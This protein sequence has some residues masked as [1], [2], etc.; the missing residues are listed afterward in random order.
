MVNN[1]FLSTRLLFY[2]QFWTTWTTWTG[3]KSIKKK[4]YIKI[5]ESKHNL[6]FLS[7]IKIIIIFIREPEPLK[8]LFK[9]I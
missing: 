6:I 1:L 7:N 5:E 4:Y 9:N 8:R 3:S 2:P